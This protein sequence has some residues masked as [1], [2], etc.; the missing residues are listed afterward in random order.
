MTSNTPDRDETPTSS[1]WG[2]RYATFAYGVGCFVLTLALLVFVLAAIAAGVLRGPVPS[3]GTVLVTLLGVAGGVCAVGLT[4]EVSS[5]VVRRFDLL[6]SPWARRLRNV[7]GI[8]IA[9]SA[10]ADARLTINS[11]TGGAD[12][13][14]FT[15][16]LSIF[17]TLLTAWYA[18][19]LWILV[20]F[21]LLVV[22]FTVLFF[23]TTFSDE[24]PT[25]RE[26]LSVSANYLRRLRARQPQ[27]T[28]LYPWYR[29]R[30]S[31][32]VISFGRLAGVVG[33][34]LI[35]QGAVDTRVPESLSDQVPKVLATVLVR[36]GYQPLSIECLNHA[37]GEWIAPLGYD[38]VSVAKPQSEY[39]YTFETRPCNRGVGAS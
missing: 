24:G 33:A 36:T 17:T 32:R 20:T 1:T 16:S 23:K 39:G 28:Y 10:L 21:L 29:E 27:L 14:Q 31:K 26:V 22:A 35:L 25:L 30:L 18:M 15:L 7:L 11:T 8:P 2:T 3:F 12:P 13:D 9:F 34:L 6:S 38:K 5:W 37:Q 19:Q 4:S